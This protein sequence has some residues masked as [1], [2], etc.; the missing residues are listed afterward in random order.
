MTNLASIAVVYP[1]QSAAAAV[2]P[3]DGADIEIRPAA[4]LA[5]IDVSPVLVPGPQGPAGPAGPQGAT[6]AQGTQ[7]PAGP[8]GATGPAGAQGATGPQGIQGNTGPQGA[9]GAAGAQGPA[10]STG[11]TGATGPQGIQGDVGPQGPPGVALLKSATLSLPAGPGVL[12]WSQI[13]TD[14]DVSPVS[15]IQVWLAP[16]PDTAENAPEALDLITLS[17]QPL[18]GSLEISAAFSELTSGPVLLN[19]MVH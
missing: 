16:A 15:V 14:A 3:L 1:A 9:A 19:Y 6:G 8:T 13:I 2:Y 11:A 12:E 4:A 10:G 7:G 5:A 18:A 17:A